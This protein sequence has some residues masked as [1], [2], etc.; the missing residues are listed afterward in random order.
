MTAPGKGTGTPPPVRFD[1]LSPLPAVVVAHSACPGRLRLLGR[2]GEDGALSVRCGGCGSMFEF[3]LGGRLELDRGPAAAG[4]RGAEPLAGGDP[5]GAPPAVAAVPA[6]A[7]SAPHGASEPPPLAPPPAPRPPDLHGSGDQ[8]PDGGSS[9]AAPLDGIVIEGNGNGQPSI[10]SRLRAPLIAL[11]VVIVAVLVVAT[12][13]SDSETDPP[14]ASPAGP[15]TPLPGAGET[16]PGPPAEDPAGAP[17]REGSG[18][19]GGDAQGRRDGRSAAADVGLGGS[20]PPLFSGLGLGPS[21]GDSR[22]ARGTGTRGLRVLE[23][24]APLLCSAA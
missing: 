9:E 18:K 20:A 23:L 3:A 14:P 15:T 1:D 11:L 10:G 24:G 21:C 19:G 13:T 5:P 4:H 12:I 2:E 17:G 7:L 22:A 6:S 16:T 8:Q